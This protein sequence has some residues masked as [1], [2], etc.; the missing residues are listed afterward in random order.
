MECYNNL[1]GLHCQNTLTREL[2][3]GMRIRFREEVLGKGKGD[4]GRDIDSNNLER[5]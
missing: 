3:I 5:K 2:D 4:L 1:S